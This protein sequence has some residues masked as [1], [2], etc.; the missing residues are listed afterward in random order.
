MAAPTIQ[1]FKAMTRV[2]RYIKGTPGQGLHYPSSSTLQI[3]GFSDADW[4]TCP[5][6]RKSISGYCMFLGD[7]L[8]SWKSKKQTTVSRSSSESEYRALAIASCEVQWLTYL[9]QDFKANSKTPALLYCDNNSARYIAANPVYHERTK[10]I[11]IDC[12]ITRERLQNNLF[13]LLPISTHD[14]VADILTKAL[15]PIPFGYLLGK[16]GVI[17]IYSPA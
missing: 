14:Q 17:N 15:E 16:L 13:H 9:L 6:T 4:V 8:V 12:H 5:D 3:K 7:S 2:L 1:H 10:H 11:E